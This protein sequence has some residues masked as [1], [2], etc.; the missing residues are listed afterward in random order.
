ML[1]AFR[2]FF[3]A[4]RGRSVLLLLC[5]VLA[6]FA[7]ALSFGALVPVLGLLGGE[8]G[9]GGSTVTVYITQAF[10]HV[11]ITPSIGA[12]M[13]LIT[14]SLIV[15]ALLMFL[16]LGYASY[17]KTR[18]TTQLRRSLIG[19]LLAARWS[20]FAS[21]HAGA[22]ANTMSGDANA[23]GEAFASSARFFAYALQTAGYVILAFLISP[24]VTLAAL[25]AGG[26][27]VAGLDILVQISRRAGGKQVRRTADLVAFLIDTIS[28]LKPLKTMNRQESFEK[29]MAVKVKE[30]RR[31]ILT[32]EIS[33]LGLANLQEVLT[34]CVFGLGLY[35]AATVWQVRLTDLV[36]VG[37][38]VFRI[39]SA[40]TRTQGQLQS[41]LELEA[42]YWRS[43]EQVESA[44]AAAEPAGGSRKPSLEQAIR[45]EKVSFAHAKTPVL[46]QVSLEIPAGS[47]TVLFGPSG[48]GKTTLLDLLTCLNQ[49]QQGRILIDGVPLPEIDT[50]AWRREI[51]YVPQE[52]N[53]LHGTIA[54]NI[55]LGDPS[56]T[57]ADVWAALKLAGADGFV[58]KMPQTIHSDV[59]EMGAKLS[60]GQRQR[61]SLARAL[62]T[63]P[64]LLVLDEV[65]SALDPETERGIVERIAALEGR[66]TI[67]AITH[68]PA[69]T[70]IATRTY[71]VDAGR[72]SQ[73]QAKAKTR[74]ARKRKPAA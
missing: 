13:L 36:V 12:L 42:S 68:R 37:I 74:P 50:K 64:K 63:K 30:L 49:P 1:S 14:G 57:D 7:E 34:A 54:E 51:G 33:K 73:T 69:W 45:F 41:A 46:K 8:T 29:L 71:K 52:L 2:I 18:I 5:L 6:S 53:L 61:I 38:L 23:A 4:E 17:A 3:G 39:V 22:I 48:A 47:I 25:A 28:N 44:R 26:I 10:T 56:L 19:A 72:I 24:Y 32:R 20:Y 66:F 62:A 11:G 67:I 27:L 16:A 9:K 31:S 35:L 65:T 55:A 60:G 59:G 58:R 70:D 15:K 43:L 40:L 21:Q